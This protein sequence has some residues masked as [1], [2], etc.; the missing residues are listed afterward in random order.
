MVKV[1]LL[2]LLGCAPGDPGGSP[3]VAAI[4]NPLDEGWEVVGR[5]DGVVVYQRPH[6]GSP[7]PEVL[8]VGILDVPPW[9]AKNAVDD[10]VADD[11]MPYLAEARILKRDERG[12]V[13]YNRVSPPLVADRDYAIRFFDQSYTIGGVTI[14]IARWR[15]ANDEGPPK[16]SGVVRVPINEGYWRFE[17]VDGGKR[18]RA[19]YWVFTDPGGAVP[20]PLA[21]VGSTTLLPDVVNGL[22]AR[23]RRPKYRAKMPPV[24]TR[25]LPGP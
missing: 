25:P 9:V 18:T 20:A 16:R 11:G 7:H 23:A 13:I 17:P 6:A 15:T 5:R 24:P 14:W 19:S 3:P 12:L 22:A 8:A 4:P 21:A 10:V 2:V 1:A